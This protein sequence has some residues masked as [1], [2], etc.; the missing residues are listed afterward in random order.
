MGRGGESAGK[1]RVTALRNERKAAKL[2]RRQQRQ[3]SSVTP[4]VDDAE[5]MAR[6]QQLNQLRAVGAVTED[7]YHRQRAEIFQ[8]LGLEDPFAQ[9]QPPGAVDAD[10][11]PD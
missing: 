10:V 4:E 1:R 5:M 7:D 3:D 9:T 6:F 2:E 11:Q 8:A